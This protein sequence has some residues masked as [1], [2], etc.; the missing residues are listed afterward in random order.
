MRKFERIFDQIDQNLTQAKR[1]A[2]KLVRYLSL[3]QV[4]C[5][6]LDT[7]VSHQFFWCEVLNNKLAVLHSR[8]RVK[9]VK[10]EAKEM[11]RIEPQFFF[12][13]NSKLLDQFQVDDIVYEAQKEI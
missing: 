12:G 4:S 1:V 13:Q 8:L 3:K 2:Q 5:T 10:D 7:S 9:H 11:D 6:H